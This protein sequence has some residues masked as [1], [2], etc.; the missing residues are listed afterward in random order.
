MGSRKIEGIRD[1]LGAEYQSR[2]GVRR[3]DF[4]GSD[5]VFFFS[6][7]WWRCESNRLLGGCHGQNPHQV[8]SGFCCLSMCFQR[9]YRLPSRLATRYQRYY[10]R[11]KHKPNQHPVLLELPLISPMSSISSLIFACNGIGFVMLSRETRDSY[12]TWEEES[13]SLPG[14]HS[15]LVCTLCFVMQW[16]QLWGEEVVLL[17]LKVKKLS[18]CESDGVFV[19][20]SVGG[21]TCNWYLLSLFTPLSSCHCSC[22]IRS[23]IARIIC[24][25]PLLTPHTFCH[26]SL[27]IHAAV[28]HSRYLLP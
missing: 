17:I 20:R 4:F 26:W 2:G 19:T 23:V 5:D 16:D 10:E 18:L 25:L 24:T 7:F 28:A 22:H 9:R 15:F 11:K 8:C 12:C 21:S 14:P 13:Y 27:Q 3:R 6:T 1:V